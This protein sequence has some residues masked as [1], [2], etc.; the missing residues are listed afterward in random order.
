[1]CAV[2]STIVQVTWNMQAMTKQQ[3]ITMVHFMICRL[4]CGLR[5]TENKVFHKK[6]PKFTSKFQQQDAYDVDNR[7]HRQ[8]DILSDEPEPHI[9]AEF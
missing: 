8:Q 7:G 1:M 6:L 3:T 9:F 2:K 4:V 5:P